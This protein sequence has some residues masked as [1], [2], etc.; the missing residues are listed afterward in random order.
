[1]LLPIFKAK[2]AEY[3]LDLFNKL[4]VP[5]SLV[6]DISEVIKQPQAEAREMVDKT[7]I[8][9]SMSA[10]IPFKMSRTPGSI[11]KPPPALGADT[12]RLSRALAA[13]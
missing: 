12:E 8:D 4:G 3:W 6:E 1:E 2:S 7:K 10:G 11:R 5:T 13:D 9:E